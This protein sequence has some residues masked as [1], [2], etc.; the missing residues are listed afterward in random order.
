MTNLLTIFI[1]ALLIKAVILMLPNLIGTGIKKHIPYKKYTAEEV[2]ACNHMK[3]ELYYTKKLKEKENKYK[4]KNKNISFNFSKADKEIQLLFLKELIRSKLK[5]KQLSRNKVLA[6][7]N[8]LEINLQTKEDK[9]KKFANDFHAI[10][11]YLKSTALTS[12]HISAITN[13]LN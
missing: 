12:E 6:I 1:G 9:N 4:L 5:N 8:F 3:P 11:H 2:I 10:Y 13:L 7:R